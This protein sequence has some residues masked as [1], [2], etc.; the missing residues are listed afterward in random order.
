MII[1]A[2]RFGH[3]NSSGFHSDTRF[4]PKR[5]SLAAAH[6][7][8]FGGKSDTFCTYACAAGTSAILRRQNALGVN[9]GVNKS[10]ILQKD[11]QW[12]GQIDGAPHT[13]TAGTLCCQNSQ[14]A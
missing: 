2:A 5:T 10:M 8:A 13:C 3:F 9:S 14:R 12:R 7:S 11:Q 1:R 6:M 4:G